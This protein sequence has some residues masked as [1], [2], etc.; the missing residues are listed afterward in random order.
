MAKTVYI[1]SPYT[2]GDKE[3][4]VKRQ[5]DA[6]EKLRAARFLPFVPLLS[7]YWQQVYPH[8][9]EYWMLMD[10]EWI[11]HC[12]ILLRLPGESKGADREVDRAIEL[13][14]TVYFDL[15]DLVEREK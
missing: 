9:Y 7:H 6:A 15:E 4:N 13:G 2:L 11:E 5:L 12:D 8:G 10:F 3:E 1:A 14:K